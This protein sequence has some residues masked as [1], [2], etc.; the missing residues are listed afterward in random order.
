MTYHHVVGFSFVNWDDPL[1]LLDNEFV[2]SPSIRGLPEALLTP[3]LGYPAPVTI[4]SYVLEHALFGLDPV[5]FHVTNLVLHVCSTLLVFATCSTLGA[6]VPRAALLSLLFGVHP[7]TAEPVAWVSGRKEL[8]AAVF[9][10]WALLSLLRE[11]RPTWGQ[12]A[13]LVLSMMSKPVTVLL[14]IAFLVY[15]ARM[16]NGGLSPR[17]LKKSGLPLLLALVVGLATTVLSVVQ[18]EAVGALEAGSSVLERV[19]ISAFVHAKAVFYPLDLLPKYIYP[20]EGPPLWHALLGVLVLGVGVALVVAALRAEALRPSLAGVLLC[21]FSYLPS[22]G[23]APLSREYADSYVYLP[24]AG[25]V[26]A[27]APLELPL[28]R[29]SR[30]VLRVV[31][32][33]T[34]LLLGGIAHLHA[35][36][37]SGPVALWAVMYRAYPDSPQVCRNLGNAYLFNVGDQRTRQ[38]YDPAKA[39]AIYEHCI[40]TL[41]NRQFYLKNLAIARFLQG[42]AE[43]ARRLFE[44]YLAAHP[45]DPVALKYL[46]ALGY[47][48][49]VEHGP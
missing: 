35:K 31:A 45:G 11:R 7:V 8:L 47:H 49:G 16:E 37:Y 26:I 13:L 27:G 24:L 21:A 6:S 5:V 38:S 48:G 46:R 34:V 40:R 18:E 22:S 43:T 25:L 3:Y 33:T 30:D 42:D 14:P 9:A 15:W 44:E 39:A 28:H 19:T 10:L 1:Y 12:F 29:L 20:P 2:R 36:V 23:I 32:A 41:G 4:A 17:R